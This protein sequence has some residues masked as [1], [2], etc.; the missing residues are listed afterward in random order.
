MAL[1]KLSAKEETTMKALQANGTWKPR[2]GY[3]PAKRETEDQRALWGSQVFYKP[4]LEIVEKPIPSPKDDEV[5]MKVG[6]VGV[7]GSDVAFLGEDAEGYLRFSGHCKLPCVI[8]HEY[9]GEIVSIGRNVKGFKAGD[10]ITAE[11]MNWCGECMACRM[12]MFNQCENLEEIGFTLDGG[13]AQYMV[14]KEK[15]CFNINKLVDIYQT[16]EKALLVGALIEPMAVAY[17]SVF[18]RGGGIMPGDNVAIFGCGPIGL[19]ALMLTKAAGAATIIAFEITQSRMALARELG[20]DYVFNPVE[21]QKQGK[22]PAQAIMEKT[23]GVGAMAVIDA[24]ENHNRTMPDMENAI[25]VGGKVMVIG[26]D[27]GKTNVTF[28]KFQKKGANI[29]AGIGSAG[30]GIWYAIIRLIAAGRID[31]SKMISKC[32]GIDDAI[33]AIEEARR[34]E[35][36]KYVVTPNG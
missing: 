13:Y 20:A 22:T 2:E 4:S 11:T 24:V 15:Y 28:N 32:F 25:A 17:N 3:T 31:P 6:G 8:G 18:T 9:S 19:S 35:G 29:T 27:P 1:S 14:V 7:C 16:K 26:L 21:L 33:Q 5:L 10:L 34:A 30:H 36:G 12:G 23:G